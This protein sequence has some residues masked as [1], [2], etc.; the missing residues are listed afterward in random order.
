[1]TTFGS[2]RLPRCLSYL[3]A[4][5]ERTIQIPDDNISRESDSSGSLT[6]GDVGYRGFRVECFATHQ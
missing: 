6:A 2:L 3:Q 4:I 1:M 5:F